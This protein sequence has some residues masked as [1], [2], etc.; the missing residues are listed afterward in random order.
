MRL[1]VNCHL[2]SNVR[3]IFQ[4]SKIELYT[5]TLPL[6][7]SYIRAKTYDPQDDNT[8]VTNYYQIEPISYLTQ[9]ELDLLGMITDEPL[10]DTLRNKEQ[11]GYDISCR[12]HDN[13]GI[14]GHSITINSQESKH[15]SNYV[16]E[17]IE[18]FRES[19][20]EYIENMAFEDFEAIKASLIKLKM[21]PDDRLSLEADR[22]WAEIAADEYK[23]ERHITEVAELN[24][25]P[26][27]EFVRFY[28]KHHTFHRKLSVQVIGHD[29]NYTQANGGA[30]RSRDAADNRNPEEEKRRFFSVNL[31]DFDLPSEDKNAILNLSSYKNLLISYPLAHTKD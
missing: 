20:L 5:K 14:L 1:C 6:T 24:S 21:A 18:V 19:L 13:F 25:L 17:R 8:I 15:T 7:S 23:F 10:F 3:F 28:K 29:V 9:V 16:D 4:P 2:I 30:R 12:V 22:N 31:M 27:S 11:L 26:K